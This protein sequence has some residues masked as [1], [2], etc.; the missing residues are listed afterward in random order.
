[1]VKWYQEFDVAAQGW[2]MTN[3]KGTNVKGGQTSKDKSNWR[4]KKYSGQTFLVLRA[5]YVERG[6]DGVCCWK[7]GLA[8]ARRD[9]PPGGG[10]KRSELL[11]G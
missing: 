5:N 2:L 6:S 7:F 8:R 1:M 11:K 4:E 10:W 3:S 9:R